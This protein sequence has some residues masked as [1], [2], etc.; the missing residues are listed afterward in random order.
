M[1]IGWVGSKADFVFFCP[2]K[3]DAF[4]IKQFLSTST[5]LT[6]LSRHGIISIDEECSYWP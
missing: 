5:G 2:N 6:A 1:A 3:E 4:A